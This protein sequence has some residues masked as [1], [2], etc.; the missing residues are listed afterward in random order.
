MFLQFS[1]TKSLT[2]VQSLGPL[3]DGKNSLIIYILEDAQPLV[4]MQSTAYMFGYGEIDSI[5]IPDKS[6]R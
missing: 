2:D 1:S 3:A 4:R 6:Q 5:Q